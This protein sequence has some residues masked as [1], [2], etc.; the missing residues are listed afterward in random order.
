MLYLKYTEEGN[1]LTNTLAFIRAQKALPNAGGQEIRGSEAY[2]DLIRCLLSF[3]KLYF[4]ASNNQREGSTS[5]PRISD[6]PNF[7]LIMNVFTMSRF[8][9]DYANHFK[10]AE[11]FFVEVPR[12]GGQAGLFE[13]V[14]QIESMTGVKNIIVNEGQ[15]YTVIPIS[16]IRSI[17]GLSDRAS[18]V[19]QG[20]ALDLALS[21]GKFDVSFQRSRCF[22]HGM[23]IMHYAYQTQ[24]PLSWDSILRKVQALADEFSWFNLGRREISGAPVQII[25][26]SREF[27]LKDI[28]NS[29]IRE[30]AGCAL[31]MGR[32]RAMDCVLQVEFWNQLQAV[33]LTVFDEDPSHYAESGHVFNE[34]RFDVYMD[35]IED[36]ADRSK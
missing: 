5:V 11:M 15:E 20:S 21:E 13:S 18:S 23:D 29:K 24:F 25:G 16:D 10:G 22:T 19:L 2:R 6:H 12:D 26:S 34:H 28:R 33:E 3:E 7:G 32:S 17:G 1:S 30:E 31:I 36:I 27:P 4:L 35:A 9:D 14:F 8:C